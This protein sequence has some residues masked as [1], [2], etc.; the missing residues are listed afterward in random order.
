MTTSHLLRSTAELEA[1]APEWELLWRDDAHATPFQHPAWLL[2]WW[3]SVGKGTLATVALRNSTGALT[4]LLPAYIY[5]QPG[6]DAQAGRR[7]LLLLLGAGTSDYLGGIFPDPDLADLALNTLL[8]HPDF[9]WDHADLHQ[10]RADSPLLAALH[11][12]LST[13]EADPCAVADTAPAARPTKL[14]LNINRYRHRAE[15]R[16]VLRLCTAATPAQALAH[17]ETL[18]TLHTRRWRER[19]EPGV[20]ASPAVQQHHREAV[21]GLLAAGLLHMAALYLDPP[22][23]LSDHPIAILYGLIDPPR[24]SA[25]P[26]SLYA[27]LIGIDPDFA[28]L[29]PGTLLLAALFEQCAQGGIP[30]FDMLRGGETYKRLWGAAPEPTFATHLVNPRSSDSL[31][32]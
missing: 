18:I 12:I 32:Q 17:L 19:G 8:T 14:R 7:D 5:S 23:S 3:R 30:R 27:Y 22:G 25:P 1:L 26:R 20:L 11:R 9:L 10:L 6:A 31:L 2:P 28:D 24:S 15:P 16:G 13:A 29:S 21:P 4:A